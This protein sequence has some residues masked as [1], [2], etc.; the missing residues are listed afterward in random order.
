ME[1]RGGNRIKW[2]Q[3]TRSS[4]L[5]RMV[6]FVLPH[7][8]LGC[9]T[10]KILLP[11]P[12]L[13]VHYSL[14]FTAYKATSGGVFLRCGTLSLGYN[15]TSWP[16]AKMVSTIIIIFFQF[17]LF[18]DLFW[19]NIIQSTLYIQLLVNTINCH[20]IFTI[21]EMLISYKSK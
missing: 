16:C 2:G 10:E 18:N 15:C 9:M 7:S 14:S 8:C 12:C 1:V 17:A 4:P 11:Y 21:V 20:N 3:R 6:F 5:P 19:G 13:V